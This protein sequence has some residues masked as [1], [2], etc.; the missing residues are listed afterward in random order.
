M[1]EILSKTFYNNTI[2]EWLLVFSLIVAA[3]LGGR[4]LFW[5][6]TRVLKPLLSKTKAK[7][8]DILVDLCEEPL[9]LALVLTGIWHSL[10]IL[11]LGESQSAIIDNIFYAAVI[12]NVAWLLVRI[13]DAFI[14]E[15]LTPLVEKSDTD[16]DD[17]LLPILRKGVRLVIWVIALIVG[18]NN[19]GYNVGALL[20]G[21]GVGGLAFALAAKDTVANLFGGLTV[22]LDKPFKI[23]DRIQIKGFD[24]VVTEIGIRSSRIQ[25]LNGT[26]VT[27]PNGDFASQPIENISRE[28]SRKITLNLGLTY[29]TQPEKIEEAIEVLK[30]I[31][32][33]NASLEEKVILSFNGFGDFALN[34]LFIYYIRS[35]EDIAVTQTK[36]DL[37]ILREFN[38]R[39]LEFAFPT[40]TIYKKE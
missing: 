22:F 37:A 30:G 8:D 24:G 25:T 3:V 29:D 40:Q 10:K 5:I 17:Q 23:G 14:K 1:S 36:I 9:V 15:Y 19:A 32:A 13:S 2:G 16:L 21:L 33:A 27:I 26:Q 7:L 11:H 12:F 18:L 4:V 39:G 38:A 31:A 20:A 28:P 35:G 6:S 34:I